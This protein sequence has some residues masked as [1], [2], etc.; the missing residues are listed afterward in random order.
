MTNVSSADSTLSV[1][2]APK[3]HTSSTGTAMSSPL[4]ATSAPECVHSNL[5]T[6]YMFPHSTSPSS[7][8]SIAQ[9]TQISSASRTI[10]RGEWYSTLH[11]LL[12]MSLQHVSTLGVFGIRPCQTMAGSIAQASA[13]PRDTLTT[14]TTSTTT[15]TTASTMTLT[16]LAIR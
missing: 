9:A 11:A 8:S 4:Q 5:S 14:T 7:T 10:R 6:T 1:C 13:T 2:G 15:S 12:G 3:N 16:N